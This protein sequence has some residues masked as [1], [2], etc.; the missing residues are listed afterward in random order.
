MDSKLRQ[1]IISA[2]RKIWL[3]SPERR[4]VMKAAKCG[5]CNRPKGNREKFDCDHL[6]PIIPT[7]GWD[8][9]DNYFERLFDGIQVA[10]CKTCHRKKTAMENKKR[11]DI[12]KSSDKSC[13]TTVKT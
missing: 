2:V 10:C 4:E 13:D 5:Y 1:K 11:K 3:Y 7:S 9:W 6:L 8:N 12:K